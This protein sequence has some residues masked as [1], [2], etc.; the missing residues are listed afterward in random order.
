[1]ARR[2]LE[3]ADDVGAVLISRLQKAALSKRGKLRVGL[4]PVAEA[5]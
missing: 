1:M 3:E 2:S 4:I 5:R